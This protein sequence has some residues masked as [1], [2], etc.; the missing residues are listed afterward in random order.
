MFPNATQN[1][2]IK[3]NNHYVYDSTNVNYHD[4]FIRN[5]N[6]FSSNENKL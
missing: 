1:T 4:D 3:N 5:N 6:N 2:N